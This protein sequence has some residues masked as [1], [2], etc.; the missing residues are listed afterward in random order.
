MSEAAL[1]AQFATA[2]AQVRRSL[3]PVAIAHALV[4]GLLW[5]AG[6]CWPA[7]AWWCAVVTVNVLRS[8]H[9]DRLAAR[10]ETLAHQLRHMGAWLLV[11]GLL[12]AVPLLLLQAAG[13]EADA[14]Y[15]VTMI[16][17]GLTVGGVSNLAGQVGLY[18]L[19]ALPLCAVLM[20]QWLARADAVGAGVALL[21]AMLFGLLGSYVRDYGL[22]LRRERQLSDALRQERDRTRAAAVARSRFF[23]AA[24]H[25]L[26]Q[27][28]GALRWYGEAVAELAR[29]RSDDTLTG[30]SQGLLRALA[31]TEPMLAQYLEIGRLETEPSPAPPTAGWPVVHVAA[32]LTAVQEEWSPNAAAR[33]L[34]LDLQIDPALA[35]ACCQVDEAGLRRV[36]DNL[37]GNALKYTPEGRITL[38]AVLL[39]GQSRLV[40]LSV[41]DTGVGIAAAHLPHLFDD[42]YQGHNAAR[43][44]EQGVG[45]GLAIARRHAER[46][47]TTIQVTSEPGR[48]SCFS[49]ELPLLADRASAAT[50]STTPPLHLDKTL[51]PAPTG[52][53]TAAVPSPRASAAAAGAARRA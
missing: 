53:S 33:A 11:L 13:A 28:L 19:W 15:L 34:A 14:R 1:A 32:L 25:D 7:I 31:R 40:K 50:P 8:R 52:T 30:L 9:V 45:L 12:E 24:S 49:F 5:H 20:A 42:F 21:V 16:L 29:Q 18:L 22:I 51:H 17:L 4:A 43:R 23:M 36:L 37:L 10:G 26:R 27:P 6:I 46:M 48:G 44:P 38:R 35:Q 39:A 3:L 41:A 47:G 2:R